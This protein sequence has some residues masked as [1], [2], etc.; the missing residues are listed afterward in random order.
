MQPGELADDFQL[1]LRAFPQPAFAVA[2]VEEESAE[3]REFRPADIDIR[4]NL[5]MASRGAEFDA[6]R[7]FVGSLRSPL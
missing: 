6:D 4:R 7:A 2:A 5:V 1:G 3:R